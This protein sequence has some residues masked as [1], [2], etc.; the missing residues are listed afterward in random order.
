MKRPAVRC[1]RLAP[2]A[3]ALGLLALCGCG[4]KPKAAVKGTVTWAGQPV[5]MGTVVFVA[6]DDPGSAGSG[7]I[8]AN[9]NYTVND[10]PIGNDKVY[11]SLPPRPMGPAGMPAPPSGMTMPADKKPGAP[12]GM[13]SDNPRDYPV[14]LPDKYKS[15]DATDVKFKVEKGQNTF[16]ITLTP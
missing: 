5:K 12:G 6:A 2:V 13:G 9:G 3:A 14:S 7:E 11:I 1:P 4:P 15:A 16:N 8:D 10:A